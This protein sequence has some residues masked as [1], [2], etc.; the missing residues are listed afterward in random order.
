M[1]DTSRFRHLSVLLAVSLIGS[2]ASAPHNGVGEHKSR[3][4][5]LHNSVSG[6]RA[7][8]THL[9]GDGVFYTM[10]AVPST[11][12]EDQAGKEDKDKKPG[13]AHLSLGRFTYWWLGGMEFS[14]DKSEF[15]ET[16]AYIQFTG[17][18]SWRNEPVWSTNDGIACKYDPGDVHTSFNLE[19]GSV[20]A[21]KEPT[22]P[23]DTEFL[24]SKKALSLTLG[25]SSR[26]Y[27]LISEGDM[28]RDVLFLGPLLQGGFHTLTDAPE[29]DEDIDTVNGWA[30]LGFRIGAFKQSKDEMN[31]PLLRY[32]DITYG[33]HENYD[34]WRIMI[35]ASLRTDPNT[36]FFLGTR[37]HVGEGEDDVRVMAGIALN[38]EGLQNMVGG[39][40]EI[41]TGK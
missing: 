2:C 17:D 5:P 19:L 22:M 18:T 26:P 35:E 15:S 7:G 27:K 14:Q 21:I 28:V 8:A 24:T 25:V 37:A 11:P 29:S 30:S 12:Y 4:L 40:S 16:N 9:D 3:L 41:F 23:G 33:Y 34:D 32:V 1:K 13:G 10:M 20:S 6:D 39:F 31:P 36:G 38:L